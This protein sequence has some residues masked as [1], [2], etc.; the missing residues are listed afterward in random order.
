MLGIVGTLFVSVL[1]WAHS[2][3]AQFLP[4]NTGIQL[5]LSPKSP[6]PGDEVRVSLDAYSVDTV[7]ATISWFIDGVAQPAAKNNRSLTVI[8]G[9]LGKN[10]T[11]KATVA[12]Q[13][14]VPFT[15]TTIIK[16]TVVDVVL[17]ADSY[18]PSFYA[19]RALP[20]RG[21]H[22][23][24]IAIVHDG[25]NRAPS[26]YTYK[27]TLGN[28]AL[29]GGAILGRSFVELE[30]PQ[31]NKETLAVEVI[32]PDGASVGRGMVLLKSVDPELFFYEYSPLRGLSTR[33][34]H[35]PHTLIGEEVTI[36]GEPYYINSTMSESD[37]KF[38]WKISGAE[39][40]TNADVPNAITLRGV[41]DSGAANIELSVLTNTR[42]PQA[43][44]GLFRLLFE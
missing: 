20:S 24:A 28:S 18:I 31:Y 33:T 3:Q 37:A 30:M 38:S 17:E 43:V 34:I 29:L 9:A 23:R 26:S 25:T 11:I 1:F 36:Y 19:G 35:D 22:M 16:P 39:T 32:G 6:A 4:A 2:A 41:G 7:G 42:I 13:S 40:P 12:P 10:M 5:T 15:L 14:G 27:W 8:A 21:S 44:R